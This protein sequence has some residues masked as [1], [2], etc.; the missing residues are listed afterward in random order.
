VVGTSEVYSSKQAVETGVRVVM[1]LA[2]AQDK[3]IADWA[4]DGD[5]KT[6][7]VCSGD[8]GHPLLGD[9]TYDLENFVTKTTEVSLYDFE[10]VLEPNS[11][12]ERQIRYAA[13]H[14]GGVDLAEDFEVVMQYPDEETLWLKELEVGE[15]HYTWVKFY[16]GDN[17][18]GML[19]AEGTDR[20][21]V[22]V[23]DGDLQNCDV[24]PEDVLQ[25][26][27]ECSEA[28]QCGAGLLCSGLT[29]A[30]AEC[31][32]TDM[33]GTFASD[34]SFDIV[35]GS[36]TSSSIEVDGLATVPEDV[37]VTLDID[38]P[39]PADLTVALHQPGGGYEVLWDS[40]ADP[41]TKISAGWG[42]ERDNEVNGT[43]TLEI[44]D[45]VTGE[46]GELNGWSMFITSRWD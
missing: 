4:D 9:I 30:Y 34:T 28:D 21:V 17:E 40:E 35:E 31:R 6:P 12:E 3:C 1:N 27:D 38:H 39:N 14:N 19:F 20:P 41:K 11:I 26:G 29:V 23:S 2:H 8:W 22:R 42:I 33:A 43:W 5:A 36:E 15:A 37:I 32:P 44:I 16:A 25:H 13:S 46:T 10:Q 45:N 7:L 24:A 18:S